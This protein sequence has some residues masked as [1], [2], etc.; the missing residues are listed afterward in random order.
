MPKR[1][2]IC[3]VK[4]CIAAPAVNPLT[5]VSESSEHMIPIRKT[6]IVNCHN[7]TRYTHSLI[8]T[9]PLLYFHITAV[10][11]R[12]SNIIIVGNNYPY[13]SYSLQYLQ[14]FRKELLAHIS[15]KYG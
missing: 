15:S 13:S 14:A 4:T 12:C 11:Y 2:L 7:N 8:N 6:N 10:Y 3:E 5:K 1:S 9:Q